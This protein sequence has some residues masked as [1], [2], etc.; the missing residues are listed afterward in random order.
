MVGPLPRR[1]GGR[2]DIGGQVSGGK[3]HID[4]THLQVVGPFPS[5]R[6]IAGMQMSKQIAHAVRLDQPCQ[7]PRRRIGSD[8]GGS[9][10][11]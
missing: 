6:S 9:V 5:V 3:D 10:P 8:V 2:I 11:V 7:L 4:T 1:N